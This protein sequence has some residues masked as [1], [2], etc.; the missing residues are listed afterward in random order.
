MPLVV[1]WIFC[2]QCE[3]RRRVCVAVEDPT[4]AHTFV[5]VMCPRDRSCHMIGLEGFVPVEEC[6]PDLTVSQPTDFAPADNCYRQ[7]GR[8]WWKFW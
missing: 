4:E 1:G 7:R 2:P 6:P 3:Y 8:S 5:V